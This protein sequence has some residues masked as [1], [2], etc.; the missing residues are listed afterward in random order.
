MCSILSSGGEARSHGERA[1]R[2]TLSRRNHCSAALELSTSPRL[3]LLLVKTLDLFSIQHLL[4][5]V[6]P[7]LLG[8]ASSIAPRKPWLAECWQTSRLRVTRRRGPSFYYPQ[9]SSPEQSFSIYYP[10]KTSTSHLPSCVLS[11][12]DSSHSDAPARLAECCTLPRHSSDIVAIPWRSC[13]DSI[14]RHGC[15][16]MTQFLLVECHEFPQHRIVQF[17]FCKAFHGAGVF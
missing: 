4:G 16:F 13:D 2:V 17:A 1:H 10:H 14:G 7:R 9:D 6:S 8:F 12:R 15:I 3:A 5:E 11:A